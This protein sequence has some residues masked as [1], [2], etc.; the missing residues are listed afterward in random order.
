NPFPF[1]FF[2]FFLFI[3][4]IQEER[5]MSAEAVASPSEKVKHKRHGNKGDNKALRV[6]RRQGDKTRDELSVTDEDGTLVKV[7]IQS[8]AD[9]YANQATLRFVKKKLFL[10]LAN[11][12]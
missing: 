8:K 11:V 4:N 12:A 2:S 9:A 6:I 5:E 7:G 3:K 1:F 10:P